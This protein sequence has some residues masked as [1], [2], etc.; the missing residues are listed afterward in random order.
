MV[1]LY[2]EILN[3]QNARPV[4]RKDRRTCPA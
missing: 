4:I 1:D 2:K 3:H